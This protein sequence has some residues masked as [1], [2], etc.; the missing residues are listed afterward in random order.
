MKD[1]THY[2]HW[3]HRACFHV[4]LNLKRSRNRRK[5]HE[6]GKAELASA[7]ALPAEDAVYDHLASLDADARSLIVGRYLE[8]RSVQDLAAASGCS[9]VTLSKRL[10]KAR[11][12]LLQS[13]SR[14]GMALAGPGLDA[15]LESGA[16]V[17][18]PPG[19][20]GPAVVAK[21]SSGGSTWV[22]AVGGGLMKTK[23]LA[24]VLLL[25]L[26]G[27]AGIGAWRARPER[28]PEIAAVPSSAV[29]ASLAPAAPAPTLARSDSAE[30]IRSGSREAEAPEQAPAVPKSA[31]L[32][33]I[34][35]F[36][37]LQN[38]DGSWGDGPTTIGDR[39]M[40]RA[41]VTA[42]ALLTFLGAGYSQLSKDTY[43]NHDAGKTVKKALLWLLNAQRDD[44]S[45]ATSGD[46]DV[47]QA[48]TTLALS[49]AYGM[50]ASQPLK[51]PAQKA[52]QAL[53]NLQRGDGSWG[54][55]TANLWA[56]EA[57]YS[58][59]LGE[60]GIDPEALTQARTYVRSQLDRGPNL[61]AMI[62]HLFLNRDRS[63]PALA[64]TATWL[65]AAPPDSSRPDLMYSYMGSL[66]L[67]QVDGPEGK[68]WKEWSE[69]LVQSLHRSQQD[70]LWPG[71]TSSDRIVQS[72]LATL[73]LETYYRY[74]NVLIGR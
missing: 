68:I 8:Q 14:S 15:I 27:L 1:A 41:G 53:V 66:A 23:G 32:S 42:L 54:N 50:T 31:V 70:G 49:E 4:S 30:G 25:G 12:E 74:A 65:A 24:A 48:L 64:H 56:S 63:H 29:G 58:A 40:D 5:E 51:E 34:V 62:G 17:V 43:E 21:A 57:L 61:A 67:F 10:E 19:A 45:F 18:V 2:R 26:A 71:R 7:D 3:I 55:L 33:S 36:M 52:V 72:S 22:A 11:E 39:V 35:Q 16:P 6:R 38:A 69:P 37:K 46:P 28:R 73:T 13:L 59:R 60:L 44:G 20:L 9:T 47:E